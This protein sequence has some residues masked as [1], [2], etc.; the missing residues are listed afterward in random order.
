MPRGQVVAVMKSLGF[1]PQGRHFIHPDTDF[2]VEFPTGPLMVGEERVERVVERSLATGKLRLLSPTD[3][4]KDRLA[5]YFHWNDKQAL[6]QALLVATDQKIDLSDVRRWS[7]GEASEE[8]FD[9]FRQLLSERTIT[10]K[11]KGR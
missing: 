5:A 3:C 6:E 2:L 10:K 7:K 8:A 1:Q 9:V 11:R 4:V